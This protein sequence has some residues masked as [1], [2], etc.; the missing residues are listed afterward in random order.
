VKI[1]LN[2]RIIAV[3]D[4]VKLVAAKEEGASQPIVRQA[5]Q[6]AT[7]AIMQGRSAWNA[8]QAGMTF[9]KESLHDQR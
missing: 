9:V 2:Q 6:I 4:L 7:R 1:A 5:Q 8:Y 3:R